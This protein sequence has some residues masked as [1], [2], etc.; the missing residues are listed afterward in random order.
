MC[1]LFWSVGSVQWTASQ[2]ECHSQT[3]KFRIV[4]S[5]QGQKVV[6]F[7]EDFNFSESSSKVCPSSHLEGMG[8]SVHQSISPLRSKQLK[9]DINSVGFQCLGSKL[10]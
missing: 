6:T 9:R 7:M 5:A 1:L 3:S 10:F 4:G 2:P 8:S